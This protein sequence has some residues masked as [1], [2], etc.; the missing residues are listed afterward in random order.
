MPLVVPIATCSSCTLLSRFDCEPQAPPVISLNCEY[1]RSR[2]FRGRN[3]SRPRRRQCR[4]RA[5]RRYPGRGTP[6]IRPPALFR[7]IVRPSAIRL[8]RLRTQWNRALPRYRPPEQEGLPNPPAR[9]RRRKLC[10]LGAD[11]FRPPWMARSTCR[12]SWAV[13]DRC[14]RLLVSIRRPRRPRPSKR[15][16]PMFRPTPEAPASGQTTMQDSRQ[17]AYKNAS[18]VRGDTR[19][20]FG[21]SSAGTSPS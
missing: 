14:R 6:P 16:S 10:A 11:R 5:G 2:G 9:E 17:G 20:S 7:P 3:S 1:G 13:G 21:V 18:V 19:Q 8:H 12:E 4:Q 15:R